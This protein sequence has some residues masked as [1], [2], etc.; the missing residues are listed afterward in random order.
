[1]DDTSSAKRGE[2]DMTTRHAVDDLGISRILEQGTPSPNAAYRAKV[3]F[4]DL[5]DAMLEANRGWLTGNGLDPVYGN[6]L[7]CCQTYIVRTPH[8]TVLIDTCIGNEK[9]HP[10]RPHWHGKTDATYMRALAAA[11]LTVADIDVVMRS[12][13]HTSELQSLLR[14]SYDIFCL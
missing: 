7:L 14:N 4:P 3:C 6:I 8:H 9:N 11:G 1:M 5:T 12:E 10:T 13:E 2:A